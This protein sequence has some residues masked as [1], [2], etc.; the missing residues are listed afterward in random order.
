MAVNRVEK[1]V[2]PRLADA[3]VVL[4]LLAGLILGSV[5]LAPPVA[6]KNGSP[7]CAAAPA[8]GWLHTNGLWIVDRNNCKVRLMSVTWFGMETT[9]YVPDGLNFRSYWQIMQQIKQLGF[10]SIR[11]TISDQMVRDDMKIKIRPKYVT[12]SRELAGLHPLQALDRLVDAARQTHLMIILDNH[13]SRASSPKTSHIEPTWNYY[14]EQGWIDDWITLT[15]R[16]ANDPTVIGFDLRNEPHT[17]GPGPWTLK[18]YL[19]QGATWGPYP[20]A[21]HPNKLWK[22]ASDWAAAAT[23]AGNAILAVNPNLLMFVEGVQLYPDWPQPGHVFTYWWGSILKGVQVDPI[24]FKVPHHLV[25]SPH[26]WGPRRA[27]FS[28]FTWDTTYKMVANVMNENWGFILHTTRSVLR[29]PIWIGEFDTCNCADW[30]VQGSKPH[31]RLP[32]G[33]GCHQQGVPNY[34]PGSQGQW[35]QIFLRYL[36]ANPEVSW[37]YYPLNGTT[38]VGWKSNNSIL[39]RTWQYVK[40]P[41]LMSDL[42]TVMTPPTQ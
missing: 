41:E 14:T 27:V 24:V 11:L 32:S 3:F 6:A 8:Y 21:K 4:A 31:G 35:F 39:N 25:Y 16:Y 38:G 18:T 12:H 10:N 30:C 34:G 2:V 13:G 23:K 37:A 19:K 40:L 26:E 20:N 29:N 1:L 9:T 17:G 33:G 5:V 7:A 36:R 28:W 22:P 15:K 42:R